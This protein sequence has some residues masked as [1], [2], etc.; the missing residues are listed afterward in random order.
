MQNIPVNSL[1]GYYGHTLGASGLIEAIVAAH[2]LKH[3]TIIPSR[4]F[5]ELGVTQLLN[6]AKEIQTIP[7][8]AC[9]KTASG[10]GGCNAAIVLRKS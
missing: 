8:A 6:V 9:L 5:N 3:N 2:S 10:F 7:L 4:G 1:K